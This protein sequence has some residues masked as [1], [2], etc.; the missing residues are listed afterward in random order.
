M[1]MKSLY[2]FLYIH[3]CKIAGLTFLTPDIP[4]EP[5]AQPKVSKYP[6]KTA[7]T[8]KFSIHLSNYPFVTATDFLK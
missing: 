5:V 1:E 8:Y 3:M 2:I 7:V 6:G 4:A